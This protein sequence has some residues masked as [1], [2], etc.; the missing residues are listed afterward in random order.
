M[1]RAIYGD[2]KINLQQAQDLA[3]RSVDDFTKAALSLKAGGHLGPHLTEQ[4]ILKAAHSTS[5]SGT[6]GGTASAWFESDM[7]RWA[8]M[9]KDQ[10]HKEMEALAEACQEVSNMA[11]AKS[12][13]EGA[14]AHE[15]WRAEDEQAEDEHKIRQFAWMAVAKAWADQAHRGRVHRG[16]RPKG[17]GRPEE[18]RQVVAARLKPATMQALKAKASE[19]GLTRSACAEHLIAK[20]LEAPSA[21]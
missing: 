1:N 12:A 21:K 14:L 4:A 19:L 9:D 2:L 13:E 7:G 6:A 18:A 11:L 3:Q 10:A 20:G 8:Y 17:S 16:G 15:A 5:L